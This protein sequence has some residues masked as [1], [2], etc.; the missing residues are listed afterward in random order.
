MTTILI[1]PHDQL[2]RKEQIESLEKAISRLPLSDQKI[3]SLRFYSGLSHKQISDILHCSEKAAKCRFSR[4]VHKLEK[5][6]K[7]ANGRYSVRL[8]RFFQKESKKT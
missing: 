2:E 1:G 3:I 5:L 6:L 4:I 7:C 8:L